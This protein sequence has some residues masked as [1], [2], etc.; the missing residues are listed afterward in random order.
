MRAA[1]AES[2][3]CHSGNSRRGGEK[4]RRQRT[5]ENM[6]VKGKPSRRGRT[7]YPGQEMQQ[8]PGLGKSSDTLTPEVHAK[9]LPECS[10][11]TA[12]DLALRTRKQAS[13]GAGGTEPHGAMHRLSF[14][15]ALSRR[16]TTVFS[17]SR[18][19]NGG[20]EGLNNLPK[21]TQAPSR[22]G[23]GPRPDFKVRL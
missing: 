9:E 10:R 2:L 5:P 22:T 8:E 3:R 4:W 12:R 21:I 13:E 1:G 17:I 23:T 7:K 14:K 19:R 6:K 16:S 15:P 18:M 20:P 11:M